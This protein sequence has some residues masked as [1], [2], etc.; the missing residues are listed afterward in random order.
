MIKSIFKLCL[1]SV[2]ELGLSAALIGLLETGSIV[3]AFILG[4]ILVM[5]NGALIS[6]DDR[7]YMRI[8]RVS[9]FR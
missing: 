7:K 6:I 4:F 5:F 3:G 1:Y 2:A 8:D 9:D